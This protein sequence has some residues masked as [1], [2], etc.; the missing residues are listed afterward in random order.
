MKDAR[1]HGSD[2][3]GGPALVFNVN[4]KTGPTPAQ[5][6]YAQ[7]V[8][9][10]GSPRNTIVDINGQGIA[11]SGPFRAGTAHQ[12]SIAEQHGIQTDHLVAAWPHGGVA[13][14]ASDAAAYSAKH[15]YLRLG[16][17]GKVGGD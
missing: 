15:G 17:S 3:K 12:V 7:S 4:P 8:M 5:K 13:R 10:G 1:G 11:P 9:H 2:S 14:L 6:A 16:R